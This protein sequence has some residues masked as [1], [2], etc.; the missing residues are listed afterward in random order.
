MTT[1]KGDMYGVFRRVYKQPTDDE[2]PQITSEL[3]EELVLALD[4]K[5][6]YEIELI[7]KHY[8]EDGVTPVWTIAL[9]ATR[10]VFK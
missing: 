10:K 8:Y 4:N 9:K 1:I 2:I 6:G 3:K 7:N 5:E